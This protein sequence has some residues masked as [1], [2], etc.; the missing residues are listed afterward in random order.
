MTKDN[1]STPEVLFFGS[2]CVQVVHFAC[3]FGQTCSNWEL[4]NILRNYFS[5]FEKSLSRCADQLQV[6][7]SWIKPNPSY[8]TLFCDHYKWIKMILNHYWSFFKHNDVDQFFLWKAKRGCC[9]ITAEGCPTSIGTRKVYK[10]ANKIGFSFDTN[11]LSAS[12]VNISFGTVNA[13]KRLKSTL[14][15][16]ETNSFNKK[17]KVIL[18][19]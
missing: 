14:D 6:N 18:Q 12:N 16:A 9:V 7:I 3:N 8:V 4:D 13:F 15:A 5:I 11:L 2:C 10:K 19:I 1:A 17:E